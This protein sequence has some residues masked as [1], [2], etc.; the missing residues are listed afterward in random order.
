MK[1]LTRKVTT[2]T[3]DDDLD[4]LGVVLVVALGFLAYYILRYWSM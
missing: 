3:N 2:M 4:L 1:H